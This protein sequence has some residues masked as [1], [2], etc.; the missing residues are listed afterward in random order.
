MSEELKAEYD[1][2]TGESTEAALEKR[3]ALETRWQQKLAE[4]EAEQQRREEAKKAEAD[5]AQNVDA[6]HS[7]FKTLMAEV[8]DSIEQVRRRFEEKD[9][10]LTRE[11]LAN[12]MNRL[13]SVVDQMQADL[14]AAT[15]FLASYDVRSCTDHIKR[16][17]AS[18]DVARTTLAPRKKFSFK[19]KKRT[20]KENVETQLKERQPSVSAQQLLEKLA[21]EQAG[22]EAVI[23]DRVG[24][25]I[26]VEKGAESQDV[27]FSN[28]QDCT[29]EI[30]H[31]TG[32]VRFLNLKRCKLYVGPI[33]G[34]AFFQNCENCIFMVASRQVRIHDSTSCDFYLH[35][36]SRPILEH[37][38]GL[39]FS[40]YLLSYPSL[41]SHLEEAGLNRQD[42]KENWKDVDDFR[43]LRQ[44]QSPNWSILPGTGRQ[45][46][47]L[48]GR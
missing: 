7:K 1:A 43:W 21:L 8:D 46:V 24:E 27:R 3:Q 19:D 31:C 39:R 35:I 17:T 9:D 33:S 47:N 34:S 18:I 38:S 44:Q 5:P 45:P 26:W 36:L 10:A 40:P 37:C 29:V 15:L 28:L 25:T 16:C 4:R 14:A 48:S 42:A 12:E 13:K 23:C 22:Q 30:L 6:F 20:R 41:Q 11:V 2:D 32:A